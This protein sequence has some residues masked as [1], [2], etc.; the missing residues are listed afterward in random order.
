MPENQAE[1]AKTQQRRMEM[2][3][4]RERRAARKWEDLAGP[5]GAEKGINGET[6]W[7]NNFERFCPSAVKPS[8]S[9]LSKEGEKEE[10][11]KSDNSFR[12]SQTDPVTIK[13]VNKMAINF[14]VPAFITQFRRSP[15]SAFPVIT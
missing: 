10:K 13:S 11:S 12:F 6:R 5:K 2:N 4:K 15:D 1:T 14:P 9:G 7:M 8:F 3:G